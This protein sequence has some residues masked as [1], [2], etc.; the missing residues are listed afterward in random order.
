M[1]VSIITQ[2][3]IPVSIKKKGKWF[4]AKC[5][6]LDLIIQ[7]ETEEIAKNKLE[8]AIGDF[9]KIADSE[10]ITHYCNFE[11]KQLKILTDREART[12]IEV[13]NDIQIAMAGLNRLKK[14][15]EKISDDQFMEVVDKIDMSEERFLCILSCVE[16]EPVNS[17][18]F[19]DKKTLMHHIDETIENKAYI[20]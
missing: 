10:V 3:L 18:I 1:K 9:L 4:I 16:D 5:E 2:A 17:K 11:L 13:E 12:D 19:P 7:G 20:K 8:E 14:E 15:W 6:R